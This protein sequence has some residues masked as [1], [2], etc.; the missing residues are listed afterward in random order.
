MM[1]ILT[2][3]RLLIFYLNL[4]YQLYVLP[5]RV[6]RLM[7]SV[8]TISLAIAITFAILI[9]LHEITWEQL[10]EEL[11]VA[12]IILDAVF[13]VLVLTTYCYIFIAYRRQVKIKKSNQCWGH[14]DQLNSGYP[15]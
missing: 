12:N 13:I 9:P 15:V 8:S 11:N 5:V 1:L 4:K 10:S 6:L 2:A 3:D 14:R 7:V